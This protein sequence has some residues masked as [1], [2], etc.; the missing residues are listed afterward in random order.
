MEGLMSTANRMV[1]NFW[2]EFLKGTDSQ[3]KKKGK[4]RKKTKNNN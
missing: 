1:L 4:K 3:K 2:H